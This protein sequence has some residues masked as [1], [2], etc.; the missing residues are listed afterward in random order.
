MSVYQASIEISASI[1]FSCQNRK[2][3]LSIDILFVWE[4]FSSDAVW[5][6]KKYFA[7]LLQNRTLSA[8]LK[9]CSLYVV[10]SR[11]LF[12]YFDEKNIF[13]IFWQF[14]WETDKLNSIFLN[15]ECGT[16]SKFEFLEFSLSVSHREIFKILEQ[17]FFHVKIEKQS[18]RLV[19]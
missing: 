19:Y 12:F 16:H 7:K 14:R 17:Y 3:E 13:L 15:C 10:R 11:A 6:H 9:T 18:S 5:V 8:V 2:S 1:F 4:I